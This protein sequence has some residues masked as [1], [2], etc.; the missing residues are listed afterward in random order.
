MTPHVSTALLSVPPRENPCAENTT[1]P[2]SRPA[3]AVA[4]RSAELLGDERRDPSTEGFG[5]FLGRRLGQDPHDRLG[6]G[7]PHE[8]TTVAVQLGVDGVDALAQ[9]FRKYAAACARQIL[10]RLGVPLHHGGGP[11]QRAALER[12]AQEEGGCQTVPRHV[13]A[14]AD[15]VAGLLAAE[16]RTFAVER[17]EDVAV[18]D[19]RRNHAH[20][21]FPHQTMEAEV[22]H[23]RHLD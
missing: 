7:W 15:D 3:R 11:R 14:K 9:R 13:I 6:T 19:I 22:R 12:A 1:S 16:N 5:L 2:A 8:H 18:A 21:L 17:L 23:R 10:L 4:E 20:A